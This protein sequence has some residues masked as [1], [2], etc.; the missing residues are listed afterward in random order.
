MDVA[1]WLRALGL[2]QYEAAFRENDV[3][4]ELLP[5]LTGEGLKALGITSFGHRHRLL[6]AIAALRLAGTPA[7][8]PIRLPLGPTE[9]L[10]SSDTNVAERRPLSVMF[11]DLMLDRPL[12]APRPR[13]SARGHPRLPGVRR[14]NH[15]AVRRLY[16]PVCG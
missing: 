15:P 5:K 7:A 13:R 3:D 12:V 1:D 4:A 11:C 6:E 8:D 9:S 10:G 16:R 14:R 2:E